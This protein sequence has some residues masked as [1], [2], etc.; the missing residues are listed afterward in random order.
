MKT[1]FL[2][3]LYLALATTTTTVMAQNSDNPFDVPL[4]GDNPN[5][6]A[7]QAY[8]Q[9][10]VCTMFSDD[11]P[12]AGAEQCKD[13]CVMERADGQQVD[14]DEGRWI[15]GSYSCV[16]TSGWMDFRTGLPSDD[17]NIKRVM[18]GHCMCNLAV[19]EVLGDFFIES[20]L[21]V[22]EKLE[23]YACPFI[24]A[25]DIV[26]QV[27][28]MAIPGP[29]KA[30]TTGMRTA[31]ASAKAFKYAYEGV[32]AAREWADYLLGGV[33]ISEGMGC[34]KVP[35]IDDLIT[36]FVPFA[37][38]RPD[39]YADFASIPGGPGCKGKGKKGDS[40]RC[41]RDKDDKEKDDK[42]KDDKN[43]QAP[44][45][46]SK[47]DGGATKSEDPKTS[48]AA[49]SPTETPAS[50]TPLPASTMPASSM[51]A[52]S[53]SITSSS[54]SSMAISSGL[55]S[56]LVTSPTSS[57]LASSTSS[58]QDD[59]CTYYMPRSKKQKVIMRRGYSE[60]LRTI[61]DASPTST[62]LAVRAK[63]TCG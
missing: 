4:E 10:F 63:Q 36:A 12:L 61:G 3:P 33:G 41:D 62:K 7:L 24:K 13:V 30:I 55:A 51:P 2:F 9:T 34:G 29:G 5:I 53:Q 44:D 18:G 47:G 58:I 1:H 35:S 48:A 19:L 50:S 28:E 40:K 32:D 27:A 38:S 52:S 56:T 25:L 23:K 26:V 22:G 39:I 17:K 15:G 43:S 54:A 14:A 31:I 21:V 57:L 16:S 45:Q 20:V 8:A 60:F 11:P 46:K 42:D 37:D 49:T 6:A 59:E